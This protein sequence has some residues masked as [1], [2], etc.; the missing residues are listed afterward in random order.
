MDKSEE[1]KST[2][3][4]SD[5][6]KSLKQ[7]I[8]LLTTE[9]KQLMVQVQQPKNKTSNHDVNLAATPV[10]AISNIDNKELWEQLTD[11]LIRPSTLV[12]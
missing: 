5:I 6:V 9:N 4:Q 7:Q 1:G 12:D 10:T 11:V 2:Q 8:A 3:A